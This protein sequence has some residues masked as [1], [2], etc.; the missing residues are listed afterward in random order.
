[1]DAALQV[2]LGAALVIVIVGIC[3][4]VPIVLRGREERLHAVRAY[5]FPASVQQALAKE[6][7]DLTGP[8]REL[9][10]Q[11]LR[12][13]FLLHAL[14]RRN[15]AMPSVTADAA[16]HCFILSTQDYAQFCRKAFGRYL[17]HVPNA[18]AKPAML[19]GATEFSQSVVDTWHALKD[20]RKRHPDLHVSDPPLLFDLDRLVGSGWIYTGAALEKLESA[21]PSAR[22]DGG[23]SCVNA[24]ISDSGT[25]HHGA[26]HACSSGGGHG[27]SGHSCGSS[28]SGSSCSG[29]GH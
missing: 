16:W 3:F 27:C 10:W 17:H 14:W 22:A 5:A 8:E 25:G 24:G 11:A 4:V 23:G 19:D 29:G 15:L 6:R 1:M 28:C 26:G 2:L 21:A 7:P 12:E 13:Y 9:A 18:E 20:L